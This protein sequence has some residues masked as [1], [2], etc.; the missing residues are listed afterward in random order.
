MLRYARFGSSHNLGNMNAYFQ[1][2]RVSVT[3]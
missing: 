1:G 3:R 2:N